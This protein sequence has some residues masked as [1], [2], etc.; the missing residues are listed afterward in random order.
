MTKFSARFCPSF[1]SPV[2]KRRSGLPT[3]RPTD[4]H[5]VYTAKNLGVPC[6]SPTR[7]RPALYGSIPGTNTIR[8]LH[9]VATK[10][11]G[12]G[13]NRGQRRSKATLSTKR[14]GPTSLDERKPPVLTSETTSATGGRK[15]YAEQIELLGQRRTDELIDKH[16]HADA[17]FV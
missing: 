17:V 2:R 11:R 14:F 7:S 10:C 16:D 8:M 9:S 15:F 4:L 3:I 13:V 1:P 6:V 12:T 5:R